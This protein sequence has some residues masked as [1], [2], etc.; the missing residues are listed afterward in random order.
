MFSLP[1]SNEITILTGDYS[2]SIVILSVI[3]ACLASYTALSMNDRIQQNSFFH[4]NFWLTMASI[5]MGLGIWSMHFIGMSALMLPVSMEYDILLTIL[6]IFPAIFASYLAFYIANRTNKTSWPTTIAGIIMG[7]GI[8]SMH[9]VGM[10]AM[11]VDAEHSYISWIFIASILIAIVVSYV[12]LYIF[13]TLQKFMISQFVKVITSI[14]MG[15][16]VASM[17][18]TGMAAIQFYVEG[19]FHGNHNHLHK[20]DIDLLIIGVSLGIAILLILFGASILLDRYGE[21]RLNYFNPITLLPNQKQ[22]EKD[23]DSP[24]QGRI[25]I[26]HLHDLEK[27]TSRYGYSFA[28]SIVKIVSNIINEYKPQSARIYHIEAN[29]FAVF[30]TNSNHLQALEDSMSQITNRLS[31]QLLVNNQYLILEMVCAISANKEEDIKTAFSDVISVLQHS[32]IK[33]Q[34]ELIEYNPR[35]HTYSL[36]RNI[37]QDIDRAMKEDELYLM[38]QPKICTKENRIIGV[39]ALLR[40]NHPEHGFIPPNRFIPVLEESE[41]IFDVTD[42]VIDKVCADIAKWKEKCSPGWQVAINIPGP[43]ITS[44]R[45]MNVLNNN[46]AKYKISSEDIELEITETSVVTNIQSAERAIEDIR[47]NGFGVAMDDF[48]TGVSSLS[49]L[50][51]L[52]IS[53]LKVDKSFID[54]VPNSDKDS[55]IIKAIISLCHSLD[56]SVVIEGVELEEQVKFLSLLSEELSIQG[57]YYSKP[58]KENEWVEWASNYIN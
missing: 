5:A 43:Y 9:Y 13:S 10:A 34:H 32:S 53:T 31:K 52:S 39:E 1:S 26:V 14:I 16:A 20:M 23:I 17:H 40:W 41:K 12:A 22:F 8:S 44:P 37:Q 6:S 28:D 45:L 56:L 19:P 18:Y 30:T 25:A 35:I 29:R 51:R 21:Y 57:Y 49:Y 2:I 27:Y 58:L 47:R 33:Y 55:A 7:L 4:R 36:E 48:G 42:W 50:K 54:G 11:K 15:L 38:Y 24:T 3:I 46:V